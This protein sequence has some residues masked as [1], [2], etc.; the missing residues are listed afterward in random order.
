MTRNA[1]FIRKVVYIAVIAV[2]LIPMSY[3]SQPSTRES[4]GGILAQQ[5]TEY[6]LSESNLGE[7]DPTSETMKF[8][9]LGMRGVAC[10]LLWQQANEHKLK[11]NWDGFAAVL[12]QISKLQPHFINVWVFQSWNMSYNVSVEFDDYKYRYHWVKRGID[13]LIEGTRYNQR[14]VRLLWYLGWVFGQ[15]IGRSDEYQQFRDLF[16]EDHDY[17]ATLPIDTNTTDVRDYEGRVDNWLIS[18]EFFLR[19]QRLVDQ[20]SITKLGQS[21]VVYHSEPG[22][23]QIRY[24]EAIEEEGVF[25]ERAKRA[26]KSAGDYWSDFGNRSIPTS[27]AGLNI[28]LSELE[29]TRQQADRVRAELD[30]VTKG[31]RD[32][33]YQQRLDSLTDKQRNLLDANAENFTDEDRALVAQARRTL[34]I[35]PDDLAAAAPPDVSENAHRL[36]AQLRD[37]QERARITDSYRDIVN[38]A[39]WKTRCDAE[40][41]QFMVD[42]RQHLFDA[43]RLKDDAILTR[44]LDPQSNEWKLGSKEVY[45]KAWENWAKVF[46]DHPSLLDNIEAEDLVDHINDYREV[47]GHLEKE[48]P[49]NFILQKVIDLHDPERRKSAQETVTVAASGSNEQTPVVSPPDDPRQAQPTP[50]SPS[51]A[52]PDPRDAKPSPPSPPDEG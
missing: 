4:A 49:D 36:A 3:L 45:E 8:A 9:T 17:H 27:F 19:G 1:S 47:L 33:V 24:S 44:H 16:R 32:Q 14:D 46:E 6:H 21:P 38:F 26:W 37:L 39:Y 7:V 2:L 25:G 30:E 52:Q 40:Q 5:R 22:M 13:Y 20:Y 50:P 35:T 12:K 51:P 18:R 23:S 31:V 41:T 29:D 48:M 34:E 10:T 28:K 11:E 43:R 42:A 15:K